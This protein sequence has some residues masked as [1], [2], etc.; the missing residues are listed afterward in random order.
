MYNNLVKLVG[1]DAAGYAMP[2]GLRNVLLISAT[3][4]QW[5]HM[6]SQRICNRNTLETQYVDASLLGR[7]KQVQR[8]IRQR[9]PELYAE[10]RMS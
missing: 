4:Y 9:G 6:I 7:V 3:P 8:A 2:Q 1:R 10:K 5:K